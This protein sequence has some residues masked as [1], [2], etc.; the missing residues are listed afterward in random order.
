LLQTKTGAA[1]TK[2]MISARIPQE[3]DDKLDAYAKLEKRSK[4]FIVEEALERYIAR[5]TWIVEKM[6]KAFAEAEAS[7][8]WTS[9][10]AMVKWLESDELL[11]LPEPDVF[12]TKAIA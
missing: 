10:E 5:E 3:L 1:M 8:E 2:T 7:G 6:D 9:N 4:S 12:R 11:P